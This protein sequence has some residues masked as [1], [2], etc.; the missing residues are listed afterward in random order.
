MKEIK[1]KPMVEDGEKVLY[2]DKE[3]YAYWNV[4]RPFA[5]SFKDNNGKILEDKYGNELNIFTSHEII[6][7]PDHIADAGKKVTDKSCFTELGKKMIEDWKEELINQNNELLQAAAEFFKI[8]YP[9]MI[10][11]ET[12]TETLERI[13]KERQELL[14]LHQVESLKKVSPLF[15]E[16]HADIQRY[17]DSCDAYAKSKENKEEK[18]PLKLRVGG[19]YK[20]RDGGIEKIVDKKGELFSYV[21]ESGALYDE[22]GNNSVWRPD[23]SPEDLI[24]EVQ[25]EGETSDVLERTWNAMRTQALEKQELESL[26]KENAELNDII[27]KINKNIIEHARKEI[28]KPEGNP[29][30]VGDK[31]NMKGASVQITVPPTITIGHLYSGK[32]TLTCKRIVENFIY[33]EGLSNNTEMVHYKQCELVND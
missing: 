8:I 30:K 19:V 9:E 25:P 20:R 15:A 14:Y 17:V 16:A 27:D 6:E 29:F 23:D 26:R 3:Y 24:E 31:F 21:G 4:G 11:N 5:I 13:I 22:D 33:F 2:E 7:S 32:E 18:P 10:N 28:L 1:L 12:T